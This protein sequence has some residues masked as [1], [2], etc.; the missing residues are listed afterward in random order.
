[1][2]IHERYVRQ[3]RFPPFGEAGQQ[4][5]Q[6]SRVLVC[7]CGAL[8]SVIAESLTRAG[9]GYIRLVDRDFLEITNLHRQVL[10]DEDDVAA[11]LPK[12]I[13]AQR[14]LQ[15]INSEIEI[16]AHVADVTFKNVESLAKDV[17]CICDGTDNFETRFLLNDASHAFNTP[18]VYGGCIGA[19]G[20]Q[21]TIVPG[22]TA[23]LRCLM[24]DIPPPGTTPTCDTAGVLGPIVNVIASVQAMEAIKIL[25]GNS[26]STS[27]TLNVFDLWDSRFRQIKMDGLRESSQCQTCK[28]HDYPWLR[29]D[30]GGQSSVLCG[31]NAVQLTFPERSSIDLE[32][33]AGKLS[34]IGS[35][36]TNP[37][38]LRA[39]IS[40]YTL[41]VFP[42]GRAIVAGT[43]DEAEAKSF[44]AQYVGS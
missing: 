1:M 28:Q 13:A 37:F 23:C 34:R 26:E 20:Q 43:E 25:S 42:D 3:A 32:V 19:E 2:N 44:Y 36:R 9:V 24:S 38:L 12:A 16:E 4:S 39:D 10:Y 31:R 11:E 5:L 29:G 14:K 33:L 41:T 6:A 22:E 30:K 35:V 15:K 17:D 27:R 18:W 40:P 7:G 21:M 8:G